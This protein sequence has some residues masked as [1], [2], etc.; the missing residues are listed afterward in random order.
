MSLKVHNA[1]NQE[2]LRQFAPDLLRFSCAAML[3]PARSPLLIQEVSR[4]MRY[5]IENNLWRAHFITRGLV[6]S[7][8]FGYLDFEFLRNGRAL[9]SL[10]DGLRCDLWDYHA[11][12]DRIPVVKDSTTSPATF[13]QTMLKIY[14]VDLMY[15]S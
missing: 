6:K 15:R 1:I 11:I 14:N 8:R 12:R 9:E 2:M 5:V 3:L 10:V 4:L 13:S 7:P